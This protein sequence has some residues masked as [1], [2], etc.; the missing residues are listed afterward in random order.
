MTN[1]ISLSVIESYIKY[2]RKVTVSELKQAF[3]LNDED[4]KELLDNFMARGLLHQ[5]DEPTYEWC[6]DGKEQALE[7]DLRQKLSAKKAKNLSEE[8]TRRVA[9]VA[10]ELGIK[11]Y[12]II[13]RPQH[14]ETPIPK[15]QSSI[16][17]KLVVNATGEEIDP[18]CKKALRFWLERQNGRA[19]IASIQRHFAIGFNRSGRIMDTLQKL[20]YVTELTDTDPYS[21][22]L[23]VLIKLE[24]LDALFTEIFE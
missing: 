23:Y 21:T 2:Y 11:D 5:L 16:P 14:K 22:P 15:T 12:Q 8:F 1:E 4:A 19:S 13:I 18:L 20:G 6:F 3:G 10:Q 9:Y 7:I 17:Q 24:D